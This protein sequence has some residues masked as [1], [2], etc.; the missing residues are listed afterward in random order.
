LLRQWKQEPA[1]QKIN[2]EWAKDEQQRE[3]RLRNIQH[4]LANDKDK[5][6]PQWYINRQGQTIVV[7]PGP[8]EFEM[9]SPATEA[10]RFPNELLHR[11][12][13]G[14]TFAIATKP[15]TVEQFL[16]FR[17]GYYYL[18]QHAPTGDCPVHG[19][20]WYQAA[21]YCNWLS[22]QEG[23][24]EKEWC[25][26]PIKDGKALPVIPGRTDADGMKL[27]PDYLKRTGYRLPTEAEWEYACRAGAVTSRYYGESE[28]LLGKYGWYLSNSDNRSWPVGGMKPNDFGLFDMQGNVFTWC[29]ERFRD[30]KIDKDAKAIEDNEDS[31]AVNEK[32]KRVLRGGSF[33]Y[34]AA[35]V[36][37]AVRTGNV[38]ANPAPVVGFRPA[39]TFR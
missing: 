2:Q 39:R 28:Q 35:E 34:K 14:R 8:V 11:Q 27:S 21:D 4:E 1:L 25:Y 31:L 20:N 9:G 29:G 23:L 30:Y 24:P 12:R 37:S 32:E 17:K 5:A 15:V 26:Q 7:L 38:P 36:R 6:R 3:Q 13:I 16:R 18:R 10:G 19:T 33:T 22:E